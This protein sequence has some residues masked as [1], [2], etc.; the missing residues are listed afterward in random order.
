MSV[1]EAVDPVGALR[2]ALG[3]AVEAVRSGSASS[4]ARASSGFKLER[5]RHAEQ[6]DY[7]SNAAMVLG[8]TLGSEAP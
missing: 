6:G 8:P 4:G 3:E 2:L 5:P 7:A 1:G